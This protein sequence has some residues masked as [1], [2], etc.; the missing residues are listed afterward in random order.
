[1]T[2]VFVKRIIKIIIIIV[3]IMI[4]IIMMMMMIIIIVI[5]I[6][7]I[8]IITFNGVERLRVS[9][10]KGRFCAYLWSLNTDMRHP[11]FYCNQ[12]Y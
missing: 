10:E 4:I 6:I 7:V 9:V 1:M 11:R 2:N 12:Y 8:I 5:I 3:I